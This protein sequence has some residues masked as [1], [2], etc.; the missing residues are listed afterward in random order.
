MTKHQKDVKKNTENNLMKNIESVIH[1]HNEEGLKRL[2]YSIWVI[3]R[4]VWID[5]TE[6]ISDREVYFAHD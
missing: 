4:D 1:H 3:R 6:K 2:V 5:D